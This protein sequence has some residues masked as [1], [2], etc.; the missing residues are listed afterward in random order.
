MSSLIHIG[1]SGWNYEGWRGI[2]YPD[3]L[4][5]KDFLPYYTGH[6]STVEVN[7]SF[8]RLPEVKT[9][10]RW[11]DITPEEFCFALKLSRFITH[12]K[13]LKDITKALKTFLERAAPLGKKCGPIL[14]QLPPG[15]AHSETNQK[16]LISA[17]KIIREYSIRAAVEFRH[18][19]WF[20]DDVYN[21]LEKS[22]ASVVIANS[23]RYSNPPDDITTADFVYF[24]FH[25]PKELFASPYTKSQLQHYA[26]IMKKHLRDGRQVYAYF[27]N[28]VMGYAVKNAGT[29]R[30]LLPMK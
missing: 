22:K 20:I 25:G 7:Y 19:T 15:F 28:D 1:T 23:S 11:A 27:N 8:Y 10:E 9:Y 6:F 4:K 26:E 13:R 24:R 5:A 17:L 2:L 21:I 30:E 16:R 3:D 18:E 29:L 12:I 14:V